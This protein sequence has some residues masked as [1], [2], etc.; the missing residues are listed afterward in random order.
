M[1]NNVSL[2]EE[3]KDVSY[4]VESLFTNISMK[5]TIDFVH[6]ENLNNKN[7]KPIRKQYIFKKLLYKLTTECRFTVTG[8]L[9]KQIDGA[10]MD[11]TV[12]VTL[13][14]YKEDGKGCRYPFHTEILLSICRR[15]LQQKKQ[16]SI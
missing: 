15:H 3:E 13:S 6:D 14:V 8:R 9:H 11:G 12:S 7:L 10:A 5:E 16:K 1:L 4:E 2:S